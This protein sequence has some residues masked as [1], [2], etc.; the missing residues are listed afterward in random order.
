[1]KRI[2]NELNNIDPLKDHYPLCIVWSPLPIL[3]WFIP[4]IGHVGIATRKIF[5]IYKIY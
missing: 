4:F 1:M 2:S 5:L 3:T